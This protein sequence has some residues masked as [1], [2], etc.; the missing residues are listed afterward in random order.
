MILHKKIITR[1]S[2]EIDWYEGTE[3]YNKLMEEFQTSGMVLSLVK[4]ISEDQLTK[5]VE[6]KFLDEDAFLMWIN[7][8]AVKANRK[9]R[10]S[11]E[12]PLNIKS[13]FDIDIKINSENGDQV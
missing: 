9:K 7:H 6:T 10:I 3:E 5:T 13:E 2:A 12:K 4:T 8:P 1:P 11:Y